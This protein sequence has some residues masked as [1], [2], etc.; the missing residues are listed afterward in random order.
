MNVTPVSEEMEA[1]IKNTYTIRLE[2]GDQL[3]IRNTYTL[4][5]V[6][7]S[8][9]PRL[10]SFLKPEISPATKAAEKE[11]ASIQTHVLDALTPLSAIREYCYN[12]AAG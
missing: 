12:Q 8:Q 9:T 11:L 4:L 7:A 1:V 6:V 10:N 2:Y 5:H 3:K